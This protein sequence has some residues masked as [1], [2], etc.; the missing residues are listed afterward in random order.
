MGFRLP[1]D[2]AAPS[3]GVLPGGWPESQTKTQHGMHSMKFMNYM[4]DT[5]VWVT[6]P[7]SE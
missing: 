4:T 2:E 6:K 3:S 1:G 7:G 5:L